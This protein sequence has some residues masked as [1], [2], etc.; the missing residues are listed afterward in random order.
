MKTNQVPASSESVVNPLPVGAFVPRPKVGKLLVRRL[1]HLL[2]EQNVQLGG[3]EEQRC[4]ALLHVVLPSHW[5]VDT[6]KYLRAAHIEV[7]GREQ[8]RVSN[9]GHLNDILESKVEHEAG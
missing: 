1:G 9:D 5:S 6:H 4:F 3:V 7:L 2:W 8:G